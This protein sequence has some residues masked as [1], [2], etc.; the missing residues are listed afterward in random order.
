MEMSFASEADVMEEVETLVR[1]LW[2]KLINAATPANFRRMTYHEAMSTYGSDK[3]DMTF[4]SEVR[5]GSHCL[6]KK[7]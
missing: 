2:Q 6:L 7:C 4:H 1:K 5:R 3:P